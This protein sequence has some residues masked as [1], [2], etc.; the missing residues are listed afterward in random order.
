[1]CSASEL[2]VERRPRMTDSEETEH[3]GSTLAVSG[4]LEVTEILESTLAVS[5][6]L[7]ALQSEHEVLLK[8]LRAEKKG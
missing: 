1:M 2:Q 8:E 3:R 6:G 5:R 7:E 4:G